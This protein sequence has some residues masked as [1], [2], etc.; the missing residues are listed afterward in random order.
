MISNIFKVS[1][2]LLAAINVVNGA[3]LYVSTFGDDTNS[4]AKGSPLASLEGA[5]ARIAEQTLAGKEPVTVWV[6]GGTY[7]MTEP[8]HLGVDDSGTADAPVT[9]AAVAGEPVTLKGS[10]ALAADG[11]TLHE[12]GIYM[13]SLNGT[14][15]EGREFNQLFMSDQRMVRA[16]F[17][18]WD[19]ENPL[20]TGSGYLRAGKSDG[21]ESMTW[22][23]GLSD[24]V[25][26]WSHPQDGIVHIF[27]SRN[28]GNFQFQIQAIDA[29]ARKIQFSQG[30]WQA[31]RRERGI[32]GAPY[33]IENIFEELDAPFEWF[34]D[35][36][37]DVLYF[38]PPAGTDLSQ[39]L[40]E[41]ALA[42][43]LIECAGVENV[44][45]EGFHLTQTRATFMDAYEDLARGDWAI[46]RGGAVYFNNS[47]NCSVK[48][49]HIEQVG[50]NGIFVD[51]F[52]DE[53]H[54]SGC[55]IEETGD[56]S[57]C[58]VGSPK[59]V[60]EYQTWEKNVDV[61][62]D[63]EP[64]P[65][66]ED[67]PRACSVTNSILREVGIYGKQTSGVIVSMAM[68]MTI[69]HCSVYEVARAGVTFN[70]GTWGGHVMSNCDI[71]DTVLDTGEHGP[72][73]AWGRERFW[74]VDPNTGFATKKELVMLDAIKPVVL[75]GNRVG[76]YRPGVSAG[77]WTIDLDD[78]SSNFEIYNN[79][80][81]GSTLKLR[82]GF[83]RSVTN[84]IMVSAVPI[85]LHV[86][87]K[88]SSENVFEHNITVVSGSIEGS[89]ARSSSVIGAVRMPKPADWGTFDYNLWWNVNSGRFNASRVVNN[90]ET[91]Q[92]SQG[93]HSL[94]ADPMFVDPVNRDYRVKPESPA[95]EL[96]FKNFPM[97]QFGHRMTRIMNGSREFA[98][99]YQVVI[100]PDARGGEVRYTLDGSPPTSTS[101]RYIAPLTLSQT[102]TVRAST[103]DAKGQEVGFEDA[104]TFT[105]VD[106]VVHQSWL[107]SLLA[108]KFVDTGAS[109][110]PVEE[111]G[112]GGHGKKAAKT[113]KM[114]L[115]GLSLVT[116]SDFPNYI[117]AS[118]GQP[119]GAFAIRLKKGS[120][121][122]KAG[123]ENGDTII[124]ANGQAIETLADLEKILGAK[125]KTVKCKVFRG[126][127]HFDLTIQL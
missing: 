39:T 114:N 76:N 63:L 71:Y 92:K 125:P 52:N 102:T 116:I 40:V 41:V 37:K 23:E 80:M 29:S 118:G 111:G 49:F 84:N 4:G 55:L 51:G 47:Q 112:H 35:V 56:S 90:L 108:G 2:F 89:G 5:R 46:H 30:G 97:D 91:W 64:G 82:D 68:D 59:A 65:K 115:A 70:D 66:T 19:F 75:R 67:Y 21:M 9:Y 77:N 8:F 13:Q 7:H 106:Q 18:N 126:Y 120:L 110:Y 34:H 58:F 88:D 31:Q 69:D 26:D 48:D 101:E 127:K 12:D 74:A 72:F 57:V 93:Q 95:L 100:R 87:P 22:G 14:A 99:T 24:R 61:I 33:Y 44:H 28:W 78:G 60:R 81:L 25:E 50:G 113:K 15:L 54:I 20:R 42:A 62:R 107:A 73:N 36:R 10:A 86:W 94:F 96:G 3:E 1:A 6:Q 32:R 27:H 103:F 104:A 43:R 45:F 17:P 11:W 123:F 119:T 38:K 79:L 85:G 121:A 105:K 53:I 83:Y 109:K 117:D 98:D 122:D 124:E 16:R